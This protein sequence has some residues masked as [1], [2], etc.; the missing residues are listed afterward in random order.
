MR[1][2]LD[3]FNS[4]PNWIKVMPILIV[5]LISLLI[6]AV[7][8]LKKYQK[9]SFHDVQTSAAKSNSPSSISKEDAEKWYQDFRAAKDKVFDGLYIQKTDE[10]R[11]FNQ[12]VTQLTRRAEVLF[13]EPYTSQISVCTQASISLQAVWGNIAEV[14][15]TGKVD[16]TTPS[17]IASMAWG[18]GEKYPSCLDM[19][20]ELK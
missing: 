13:G 15:R 6:G 3:Q 8:D 17:Y 9:M 20:G 19:I 10:H 1:K 5:L 2:F 11:Q 14:G 16:T 7:I 18:G 4:Y 12:E